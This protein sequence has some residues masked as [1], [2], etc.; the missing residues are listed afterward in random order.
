MSTSVELYQ[1]VDGADDLSIMQGVKEIIIPAG[2]Y[3]LAGAEL[4][5]SNLLFNLIASKMGRDE[6]SALS[7]ISVIQTMAILPIISIFN[8]AGIIESHYY[9]ENDLES[10]GTTFRQSLM[11]S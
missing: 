7:L 9:K 11:A 6:L 3:A 1:R 2:P 10:V 8:A 5:A 4:I